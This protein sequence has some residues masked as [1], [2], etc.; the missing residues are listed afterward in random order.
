MLAV[1]IAPRVMPNRAPDDAPGVRLRVLAANVAGARPPR[2]SS[3]RALRRWR[4]DVAS[5][6]ELPPASVRAYDAQR[7]SATLLPHQVLRPRPGF[8]GTGLYSRIPLREAPAPAGTRFAISAASLA[9]RGAAPFELYSR[10]RA[11]AHQPRRD[12]PTGAT[13]CARCPGRARA[14]CGSWPATSTPRS[15][16]PSCGACSTAATATPPSRPGAGC[17]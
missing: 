14:A 12:A 11:G 7:R 5:L 4:V 6:I 13:T 1:A 16:T 15:T 3:S 17:G 8:S 9:P 2:P 10:P